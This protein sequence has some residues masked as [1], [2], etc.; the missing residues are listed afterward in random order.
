MTDTDSRGETRPSAEDEAAFFRGI[1]TGIADIVTVLRRDGTVVFQ[2]PSFYSVLGYAPGDIE[3]R[4]FAALIH[5]DDVAYVGERL[6]ADESHE[7]W[8]DPVV[9]RLREKSGRWRWFQAQALAPEESGFDKGVV[10]ISRDVDR[11]RR[12]EIQFEQ[13]E[14]VANFGHWRWTLDGKT[15]RWSPGLYAMFGF[16][17]H[18]ENF[19]L[20][21]LAARIHPGDREEVLARL[22]KAFENREPFSYDCRF[23][24]AEGQY[25]VIATTGYVE[26][27]AGGEARALVGVSQDI[28]ARAEAQTA[29]RRSEEQYRLLAERASD[30]IS[31]VT[32]D[33]VCLF[34]SPALE[35]VLGF[36]PEDW[37][38]H[39]IK[40]SIMR[41][42]HAMLR[43]AT[44]RLIKTDETQ[45]VTYRQFS[46]DGTIRWMETRLQAVRDGSGHVHELITVARDVSDRKKVELD[47]MAARERAEQANRT[48]SRFLANMSH[49]LRTPLNA[50]IGFSD[51][52]RQEM[53]GALGNSQY[54]EYT[55]LIHE[56]GQLLL[57]LINDILDMSKIEA[58]KFDLYPEDIE[59]EEMGLACLRLLQQK[60]DEGLVRLSSDFAKAPERITADKRALKQIL[61]NLL[62]NAV[63][64]TP[65]GGDVRLIVEERGD[66]I[67]FQVA[68]TGIGIPEEALPRLTEPFEQVATD[69]TLAQSG[70]GLGLALVKA[71]TRLHGG[72]LL[73]ESEV[74]V[75]TRV[76]VTLPRTALAVAAA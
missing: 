18:T 29:L 12:L 73:I 34:V 64:F 4:D 63:K 25:R 48:K 60:A 68:D 8:G 27:D 16:A 51:I 54:L 67:L 65:Q 23:K 59:L 30:I 31:R 1:V 75:G 22:T 72:E 19:D 39:D 53:F 57:D 49:E 2:S 66:D 74:G 52:I 24:D 14:R 13:A 76:S 69:A 26:L 9:Y 50:I 17:P 6:R 42:D 33:G 56:S 44:L 41:E 32:P 11:N 71:L 37:L 58:G 46:A 15:P 36:K 28:T 45:S 38:G 7:D 62:S 20:D 70:S 3:E 61:L 40:D 55:Q 47:L 5:P 35:S 10:V 43:E 21:W